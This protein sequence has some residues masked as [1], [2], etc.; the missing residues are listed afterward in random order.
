MKA[1]EVTLDLLRS[2]P[3]PRP[4]GGTD[5]DG[6]GRVL[7]IAGSALSPGASIL[8]GEAAL[9]SGAG[10]LLAGI[11][12]PFA[13]A[14]GVAQPE[15]GILAIASTDQGEPSAKDFGRVEQHLSHCD[16]VLLGPGMVN[17][18]NAAAL[19]RQVLS[20]T[21]RA[22]VLDAAAITGLRNDAATL[23]SA[24][25]IPIL[26]PHAG[27]VASL[28]GR[29][30]DDIENDPGES[31]ARTASDFGSII[32]LKGSQTYI[33]HPNGDVWRHS[34]GV[35]GLGTAGSGDVL[36]GLLAGLLSRGTPADAACLWSVYLHAQAGSYLADT[37]GSLGFL[38]RQL[39]AHF[40]RLL[41]ESGSGL[42]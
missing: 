13:M 1:L 41:D 38:A 35:P 26:T 25:R 30:R 36:A 4:E 14:V 6:R 37:V 23:K 17:E 10:K 20:V 40:P 5:K 9:R 39:P 11:A 29:S 28:T 8:A 15:F 34:G 32:I 18:S 16:S 12:E 3:I 42:R 31:A 19:A 27:E 22:V 7:I 24:R 21:D 33:A 2:M